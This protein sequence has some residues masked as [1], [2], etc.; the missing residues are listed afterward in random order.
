M[1]YVPAY[2]ATF[3]AGALT[4]YFGSYALALS[5]ER[6]PS[7]L[8]YGKPM[9]FSDNLFA[10]HGDVYPPPIIVGQFGCSKMGDAIKNTVGLSMFLYPASRFY[11]S[12]LAVLVY[13]VSGAC[14]TLTWKLQ[15][16]INPE[17]NPTAFDRNIG[18]TGAISGLAAST[19]F[20]PKESVFKT[21]AFAPVF[22]LAVSWLAYD[23]YSEF[24]N[25]APAPINEKTGKTLPSIRQ[26]GGTGAAIFG[27]IMALTVLSRRSGRAMGKVFENNMRVK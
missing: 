19:L 11:G 26:W 9:F 13:I 18:T 7:I 5:Y 16:A 14:A 24:I 21:K 17:K 23:F 6:S 8:K 2:T 20:F 27:G 3:Y 22:P 1:T 4:C 25:P 10:R 15:S 12:N